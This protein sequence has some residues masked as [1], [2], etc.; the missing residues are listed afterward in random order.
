MKD[1]K[2]KTKKEIQ[3]IFGGINHVGVD[4]INE[5]YKKNIELGYME[6]VVKGEMLVNNKR[7]KN[8]DLF[9]KNSPNNIVGTYDCTQYK[10]DGIGYGPRFT[11]ILN[12][13]DYYFR[14]VE[15]TETYKKVQ[16]CPDYSSTLK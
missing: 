16:Y 7:F 10:E 9:Y 2:K 8:V 15:I 4:E 12:H 5:F 6:P 14:E 1:M 11:F 3:V 13:F